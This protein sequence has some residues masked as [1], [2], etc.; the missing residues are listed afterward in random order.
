MATI[1]I[2][3]PSCKNIFKTR[4]CLNAHTALAPNC[5]WVQMMCD[6]ENEVKMKDYQE[7][8]DQEDDHMGN[9]DVDAAAAE[10]E[11]PHAMQPNEAM[12]NDH[13]DAILAVDK[14]PEA[15]QVL[16]IDDAAHATYTQT[17]CD[18]QTEDSLC[19]PFL[20]EC[21]YEIAQWAIQQGPSQNAFSNFLSINQVKRKLDLSY[22]NACA[23]HQKINHELPGVTPWC[24]NPVECI[25]ELWANPAYLDHLTYALECHFTDEGKVEYI[26]DELMS[27]DW[28]LE[29]QTLLPDGTALVPV[30]L[31]SDKTQLC[32][33]Q[34]DKTTYPIYLTIGNI[35]KPICHKP[36]F[37]AQKLIGYLPTISLDGT[38]ISMVTSSLHTGPLANGIELISGDGA[39]CLGFPVLAAYV[40]DYPE[41]A[42]ENEQHD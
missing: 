22:K 4:S 18:L 23:L 1:I 40:A 26:Y 39:V 10:V 29:A 6:A 16:W 27:G 38:D 30:I 5:K 11:E 33:F 14:F 13:E 42:L 28:S 8:S 2:H 35:S 9:Q 17:C 32:Q 25:K 34:G 31:S 12:C 24:H 19:Y 21:D 3:Y 37:C 41:R 7:L 20:S 36:S 15:G